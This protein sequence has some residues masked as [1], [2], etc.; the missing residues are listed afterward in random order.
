M[1]SEDEAPLRIAY[2]TE[3]DPHDETGVLN[4]LIGQVGQWNSLGAEARI[5]SLAMRQDSQ[6]ALD[7]ASHGEVIG[8]IHRRSLEAYPFARLGYLNKTL[9]VGRVVAALRR[10]RPDVIYY[11]QHGPWYP[12]LG[13][14]LSVAP[15]VIEINSDER[16]ERDLWGPAFA[17]LHR[18]TQGRILNAVS[19]FVAVTDEIASAYRDRGKP[20]EIIPNGF[21]GAAAPLPPTGNAAPA[22]VFVGSPLN[23][24]GSW[25]G[26]DKIVAL[27]H[28]L[29]DSSFH[30]VGLSEQDFPGDDIPPNLILHGYR[31]GDDLSAI[32]AQSD[33]GIGTLALYRKGM[34][35]ACP[36]KV[37][38]YLM[39]GLPVVLGYREAE[40][41]LNEASYTLQIGNTPDNVETNI[42]AIAGFGDAWRGRRVTENLDFLS[43]ASKERQRLRFLAEVRK[44]A[45]HGR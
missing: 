37:R 10:F 8:R 17:A 42:G 11:R 41:R 18:A 3:W 21:W 1:R 23:G 6:P 15:T 35:E 27:A 44:A 43:G 34:D 25:H 22:Y 9:S 14:I 38:D 2:F 16:A 26:A 36:L 30:I 40:T 20:M 13:R 33:V 39:R 28:A 4:K 7:F 12:G 29:P 32:L 31:T 45:A 19:G 5:F 24:G